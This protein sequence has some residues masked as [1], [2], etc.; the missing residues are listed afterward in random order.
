MFKIIAILLVQGHFAILGNI[1]TPTGN[2]TIAQFQKEVPIS[3][4]THA[5]LAAARHRKH[6]FPNGFL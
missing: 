2:F 6:C 1:L 3:Q 5:G 4:R